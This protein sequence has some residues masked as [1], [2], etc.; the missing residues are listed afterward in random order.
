MKESNSQQR[1]KVK[2]PLETVN[3]NSFGDEKKKNKKY[4]KIINNNIMWKIRNDLDESLAKF[5][6]NLDFIRST[7]LK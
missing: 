2:N 3:E 6:L 5:E 1:V 4:L 7:N